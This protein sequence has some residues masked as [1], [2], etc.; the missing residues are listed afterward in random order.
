MKKSILL[1]ALAFVAISAMSIQNVNA[2]VKEEKKEAQKTVKMA[3]KEQ[4]PAATMQE[5][6]KQTK[7]D[8]CAEKKDVKKGDCCAEKKD[9]KHEGEKNVKSDEKNL[10]LEGK[11][12]KYD[13]KK[14]H[15][16]PKHATKPEG[17]VK[18]EQ[19]EAGDIQK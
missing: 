12:M 11:K 17:Q 7:G 16:H 19:K 8:C 14:D 5:P 4:A 2:Q 1:G 9:V 10:K 13:G 18:K 3:E 15:K 6:V